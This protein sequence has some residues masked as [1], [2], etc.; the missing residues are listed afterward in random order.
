VVL[1]ELAAGKPPFLEATSIATAMRHVND[2]V[3]PLRSRRAGI[4]KS[5]E[6]I[7][8]KALEKDPDRRYASAEDMGHA[9][10]QIAPGAAV[11]SA[12]PRETITIPAHEGSSFRNESKWL[13]P[14]VGLIIGAIVL[15]TAAAALFNEDSPTER[16]RGSSASSDLAEISVTQPFDFDPEGDGTEDSGGLADVIDDDPATSWKTDSYQAPLSEY[17]PGV[18]LLFDLGNTTEVARVEVITPD[19]DLDL[20]I[21]AGDTNP[22]SA[23]SLEKVG[24][25]Q[26]ASGTVSFDPDTEARYWVIW[27]TDLP[28]GSGGI[29]QIA[30]VRFFGP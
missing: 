18:G 21:L 23:N 14:V 22:T 25:E 24:E 13:V 2:D 7:V 30:E 12:S 19:D 27:I 20:Q 9:L 5:L 17:K 16:R 8:M 26:G 1:Y 11:A 4:S 3:P 6:T 28:G 10:Q 15:A 29:A